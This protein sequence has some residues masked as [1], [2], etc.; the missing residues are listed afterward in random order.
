MASTL[1]RIKE[2]I[3]YKRISVRK[4]EMSIGFSNGAFSTQYKKNRTIGIDKIEKILEQY[5]EL[6][7]V[8]LL[9][10]EGNMLKDKEGGYNS[11]PSAL[12]NVSDKEV[13]GYNDNN[14][15]KDKY[16]KELE[17]QVGMLRTELKQKQDIIDGFISG[18][19]VR[20]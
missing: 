7:P 16:I 3:D 6:N 5:K 11:V 15:Y 8:W 14:T 17:T 18:S 19:I 20:T 12:D 4:F 9:T 2:F 10:G 1:H 13:P